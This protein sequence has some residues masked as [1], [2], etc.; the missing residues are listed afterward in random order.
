MALLGLISGLWSEKMDHVGAAQSFIVMPLTMLSG[1]F[2]SI[3]RFPESLRLVAQLNPIFYMID[4]FRAGF[5]GRAEAIPALNI[6]VLLLLTVGLAA[7]VIRLFHVG[8]KI[9][10]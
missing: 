4:G 3:E 6:A 5:I 9:R 1:T 8:Y 10:T 7:L 2:F